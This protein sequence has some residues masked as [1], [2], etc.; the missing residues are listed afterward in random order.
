MLSG[1]VLTIIGVIWH[2][3]LFASHL[4]PFAYLL[5]YIVWFLDWVERSTVDHL[6]DTVLDFLNH[7]HE[8][9]QPTA[10]LTLLLL[11][12]PRYLRHINVLKQVH[13][14]L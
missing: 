8:L 11:G 1:L 10:L 3:A 4:P 5:L 12:I 6:V 7:V 2:V 14:L 9:V 13:D